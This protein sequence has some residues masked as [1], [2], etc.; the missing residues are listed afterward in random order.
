MKFLTAV[1]AFA[2]LSVPLAHARTSGVQ[3]C[4]PGQQSSHDIS[5]RQ[6]ASQAGD[7]L[8]GAAAQLAA[9]DVCE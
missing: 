9:A 1:A 8:D 7:R 6:L 3:H 5:A 2:L 4:G